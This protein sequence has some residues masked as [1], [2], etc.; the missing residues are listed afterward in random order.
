MVDDNLGSLEAVL[1][2]ELVWTTATV[3]RVKRKRDWYD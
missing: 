2:Q 3:K 1:I